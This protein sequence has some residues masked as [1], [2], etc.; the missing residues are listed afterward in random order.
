MSSFLIDGRTFA[1]KLVSNVGN[2]V[3][4]LIKDHGF[5]PGLAV[6]LVGDHPASEV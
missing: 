3:E 2:A 5:N 6:V 1:E 4:S